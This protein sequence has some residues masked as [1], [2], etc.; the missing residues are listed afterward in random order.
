MENIIPVPKKLTVHDFDLIVE[1]DNGQVRKIDLKTFLG[2]CAKANELKRS[3]SLCKTAYIE[4]G[5]SITWQNGFSLDPDVVYEDGLALDAVSVPAG[6]M[7][8][9][10]S[11]YENISK[12]D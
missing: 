6:Y 2:S 12:K 1:F 11:H 10:E 4:D 3:K 5:I 7:G 9:L 8:R